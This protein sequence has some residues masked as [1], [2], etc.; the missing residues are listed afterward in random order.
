MQNAPHS[1]VKRLFTSLFNVKAWVDLER[2]RTG[3]RYIVQ[4]CQTYFVPGEIKEIESFESA[5]ARLKLSDSELLVRQKGLL[6]LSVIMVSAAMG[7]F[8]YALY[9]LFYGYFMAVLISV[10]VMLIALALAFRYHFWY[11][12]IKNKRLGC[13][14]R[15]W[16]KQ[17]ILGVK[18]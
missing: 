10:V 14:L 5:K 7:I 3:G 18:E 4:Q 15:E 1:R 11:F 2:I 16:F 13:S 6:R 17:V 8:I 9:N 12:Q